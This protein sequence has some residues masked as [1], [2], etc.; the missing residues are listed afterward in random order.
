MQAELGF[1]CESARAG[2]GACWTRHNKMQRKIVLSESNIFEL[3][4]FELTVV[5]GSN[6]ML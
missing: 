4:S 6:T 5:V 2:I 1:S 3:G